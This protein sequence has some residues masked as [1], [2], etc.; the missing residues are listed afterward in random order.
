M[1]IAAG[2]RSDAT[3]RGTLYSFCRLGDWNTGLFALLV[4]STSAIETHLADLV[5]LVR[6]WRGALRRAALS[7]GHSGCVFATTL[8]GAVLNVT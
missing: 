2:G 8:S 7:Q 1:G 6:R 4:L 3:T 5:S